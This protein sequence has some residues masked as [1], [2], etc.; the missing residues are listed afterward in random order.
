MFIG[1]CTEGN[2]TMKSYGQ[3]LMELLIILG[4]V[5]IVSVAALTLLGSNIG[6]MIGKSEKSVENFDPFDSG[7]KSGETEAEEVS[8]LSPDPL[9]VTPPLDPGTPVG[10]QTVG[11]YDVTI[12]D[13]GSAAFK[14]GSQDV[15]LPKDILDL[16]EVVM[17]TT[18]SSGFEDIVS[19]IAYLIEEHQAEYP[20][21]DVPVQITYGMGKRTFFEE[22][23]SGEASVNTISMSVGDHV[24]LV[25]QDQGCSGGNTAVC[26]APEI[27]LRSDYHRLEM[28]KIADN[29]YALAS[30][31]SKNGGSQVN[32]VIMNYNSDIGEFEGAYKF[33]TREDDPGCSSCL[34]DGV[35]KFA[36]N[37]TENSFILGAN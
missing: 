3:N 33:E 32:D 26:D 21:G 30:Y 20:G 7:Y 12:Y 14:V 28:N 34:G 6:Q 9:V 29:K 19:D 37:N 25:Q 2:Y 22:I 1:G 36:F 24:I 16:Q 23:L 31:T 5:S 8:L 4:L 10:S 11:S 35:W 27:V 15:Y 18:G 17:T 13:D